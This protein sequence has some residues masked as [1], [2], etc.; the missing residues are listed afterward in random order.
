MKIIQG[1]SLGIDIWSGIER[2]DRTDPE[3]GRDR[4]DQDR[5]DRNQWRRDRHSRYDQ[6]GRDRYSRYDHD[7][8]SQG[9]DMHDH[10]D[11]DRYDEDRYEPFHEGNQNKQSGRNEKQSQGDEE[12]K[13]KKKSKHHKHKHRSSSSSRHSSSS[14]SSSDS[15]SSSD[16]N[17][18][19]ESKKSSNRDKH[20]PKSLL[21]TGNGKLTW[22]N[23]IFQFERTATNRKWS[24]K[25]KF[26]YFFDCLSDRA[27]EYA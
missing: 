7:I 8:Y 4:Y 23:F 16:S 14:S 21:Y 27:L 9:R 22:G 18:D 6:W 11:R 20:L 10:C 13:D 19:T 2:Y 12:S 1:I 3:S 25:E 17:S 24:D 5:Y 26:N 15:D